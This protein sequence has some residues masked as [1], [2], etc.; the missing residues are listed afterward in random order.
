[1]LVV[2]KWY[3]NGT[4]MDS[5]WYPN[6]FQIVPKCFPNMVPKWIPNMVPKWFPNGTQMVPLMVPQ[7]V[8]KWYPNGTPFFHF[9][10]QLFQLTFFD[11]TKTEKLY[12]AKVLIL[13]LSM[14]SKW[15]M[16]VDLFDILY[17]S[18][19]LLCAYH[20]KVSVDLSLY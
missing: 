14:T 20:K 3:P 1:M 4:Q 11:K 19:A 17:I 5:K 13:G 7:M 15:R 10:S 2:S 8:S 18:T 6:G 12:L 16:Y 9:P